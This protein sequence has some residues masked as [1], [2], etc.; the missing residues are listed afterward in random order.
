M[1]SLNGIGTTLYGKSEVEN[2]GSYIATKWFILLLLPVIPLGSYR[3]WRGET[4]SSATALIGMPGA[5]TQYK[6]TP[7]P[8]NWKQ[9]IQTY[10]A[11]YGT[12]ALIILDLVFEPNMYISKSLLVIGAIYG[13][14]HLFK[15][16]KKWWGILL[17]ISAL[18]IG[19][20]FLIS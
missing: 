12:L 7:V 8:M 19:F 15:T 3:V 11:I 10:L 1:Y 2:D 18:V 6:M 17:I 13:I 9:V 20:S 5:T 16:G 14:Y 4:T